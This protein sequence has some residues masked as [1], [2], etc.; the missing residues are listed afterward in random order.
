MNKKTLEKACKNYNPDKDS[1]GCYGHFLA[2]QFLKQKEN[3]KLNK[4]AELED[5]LA[6]VNAVEK[7]KINIDNK[8]A[9]RYEKEKLIKKYFNYAKLNGSG[10][11]NELLE[12]CPDYKIGSAFKNIYYSA[13]NKIKEYAGEEK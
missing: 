8:F 2:E 10:K 4:R 5:S 11:K 1:N 6:F 7:F 12:D 3:E 9:D 13:L